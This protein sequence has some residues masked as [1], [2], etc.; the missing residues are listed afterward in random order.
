M[1]NTTALPAPMAVAVL[2][3]VDTGQHTITLT[4]LTDGY[5]IQATTA[6]ICGQLLDG[7]SVGHPDLGTARTVFDAMFA[8]LRTGPDAARNAVRELLAAEGAFHAADPSADGEARRRV[9]ARTY[10]QTLSPA[11]R[12]AERAAGDRLAARINADWDAIAEREAAE[13]QARRAESEAM[14][15]E[16]MGDKPRPADVL[17]ALAAR[18]VRPQV[19]PPATRR[20][21]SDPVVEALRIAASARDGRVYRG[22]RGNQVSVSVLRSAARKGYL[23][24]TAKPG[25]RHADWAYGT[26][27]GP[28]E[29]YL[30]EVDARTELAGATR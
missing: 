22:G 27:T 17:R 29:R 3:R 7:L 21:V 12:A 18:T 26:L 5:A 11:E 4:R 1:Q 28:G 8:G 10:A 6:G 15:N 9:A 30:D 20:P 14:W 16:I 13:A 23:K 25:T 24:L 19:P 2:N